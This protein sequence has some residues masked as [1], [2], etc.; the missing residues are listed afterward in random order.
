MRKI[1]VALLLTV[2]ATMSALAAE[3]GVQLCQALVE[4]GSSVFVA[5][6][7]PRSG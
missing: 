5:L 7:S 3:V 2:G 6:R 4:H 1:L